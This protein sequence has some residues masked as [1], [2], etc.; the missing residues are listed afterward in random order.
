VAVDL[1]AR[2][3][4]MPIMAQREDHLEADVFN[5]WRRARA[6][7]GSP[8]RLEGLGLKQMEVVL[9][10]KYWVCVD[11][12]RH[13]C[14]ILAWVEIEDVG[15]DSLHRPIPCKLNYYHFA[16]S[17]LRARVLEKVKEMLEARLKEET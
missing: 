4:D 14:P 8:I 2:L 7:W 12:I 10:E 6:R 17:A 5:V 16:A 9:T 11:A 3:A 15:R 1:D 13:D